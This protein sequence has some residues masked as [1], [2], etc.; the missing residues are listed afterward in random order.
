MSK[1]IAILGLGKYGKSLAENLYQMG[2]DVL[3]ADRNAQLIQEYA[4]RVTTAMC[5]NLAEETEIR[6]LGLR[7]MDIVVVAMGQD[8]APSILSVYVAKE[9]GVPFVLAKAS[10]Q[11][12]ATLLKR[13]GADKVV[14]PE[15][16]SGLRSARILLSSSFLDFFRM[17]DNLS[18]IE[19]K[20]RLEWVGNTLRQLELRKK[21]DIN[22]I[23]IKSQKGWSMVSPDHPLQAEDRILLVA[24]SP[25][26][27]K[28]H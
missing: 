6:Q 26:L 22:V 19:C 24:Q 4:S 9:E 25:T 12:M 21:H 27:K 10:S 8:L 5:V 28:F 3:V 20:P 13:A 1:S 16:E 11:S 14:D 18:I 7:N 23:A 17:D 2:A 15:E